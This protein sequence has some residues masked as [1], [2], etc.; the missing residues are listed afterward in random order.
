MGNVMLVWNSIRQIG[1]VV[2]FVAAGAASQAATVTFDFT[3][4]TAKGSTLGFSSGGIDLTVGAN[5][6]NP[7]T[8]AI[9]G[10]GMVTEA[11]VG[12][13]G[14][15]TGRTDSGKLDGDGVK[16][17]LQFYFSQDVT[18]ESVT[19]ELIHKG[20]KVTGFVDGLMVG[21]GK[22]FP[23]F[24][25]SG[26]GLTEDYFGAGAPNKKSA[27]RISSITVSVPSS[28]PVPAA[29]GLLLSGLGGMSF[30]RRKRR[31]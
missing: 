22:V 2:G 14:E 13:L 12:G 7:K 28:V 27:F 26:L 21:T 31:V 5:R 17:L 1:L 8:G 11:S 3:G 15:K 10:K 9:F 29:G 23:S 24:D 6:F 18:I 20:S 19:F 4:A 30:L 16:E 25:L